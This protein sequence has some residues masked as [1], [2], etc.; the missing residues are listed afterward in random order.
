MKA[1][2]KNGHILTDANT[3]K[4]TRGHRRCKNCIKEERE[5]IIETIKR[6]LERFVEPETEEPIIENHS[7]EGV[8]PRSNLTRI[9]EREMELFVKYL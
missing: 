3:Y 9:R 7:E 5:N 8:E 4:D 1:Y 6:L 2:C